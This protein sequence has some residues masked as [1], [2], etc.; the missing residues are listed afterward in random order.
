[1]STEGGTS[2]AAR[3]GAT[4]AHFVRESDFLDPIEVIPYLTR[5][6]QLA[7]QV[8]DVDALASLHLAVAR[9]ECF[10][11]HC[12]GAHHHL[13]IARQFASRSQAVAL[14]CTVDVVEASL[15]V[16]RRQSDAVEIAS[17]GVPDTGPV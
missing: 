17:N 5:L 7:S 15:G 6:R 4:F 1:M 12:L 9:V 13:D 14:R 2:L 16:A 8:G 10:R 3:F 11:G